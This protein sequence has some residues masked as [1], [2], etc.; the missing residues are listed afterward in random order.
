MKTLCLLVF[1]ATTNALADGY[2]DVRT[3]QYMPDVAGGIIDPRDGAFHAKVAGGYVNTRDGS[4][5]PAPDD[6][7]Q[8]KRF[9]RQNQYDSPEYSYD[10]PIDYDYDYP[11]E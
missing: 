1:L 11:P 2:T 9:V 6:S 3:G 7:P 8:Q 5:T 10:G 4:F